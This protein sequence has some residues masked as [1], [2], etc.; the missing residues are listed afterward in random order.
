MSDPQTQE[1]RPGQGRQSEQT[2]GWRAG[3][4][5]ADSA[6]L[7]AVDGQVLTARDWAI[8]NDGYIYG[9]AD[10][11]GA[12]REEMDGE[13]G[14]IQRAGAAVVGAAIR[15]PERDHDADARR[16]AKSAAYWA[17]RRGEGGDA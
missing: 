1:S 2:N 8:W 14:A 7:H 5:V 13:L 16:A 11:I 3:S 6:P 15:V 12:G 9:R 4:S 10:G 17:A